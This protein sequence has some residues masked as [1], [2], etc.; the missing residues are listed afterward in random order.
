MTPPSAAA[1]SRPGD[2]AAA[3]GPLG[4]RAPRGPRRPVSARRGRT[5]AIIG[6]LTP[7]LLVYGAFMLYPL[8]RVVM[9][10][11]YEWDG[12]GVGR[13]VGV[14]NYVTTFSDDRLAGAFGHAL[15]LIVFYALLPLV[16]GLPLAT[17]LTRTRVRGIGLFRTLVFLPQVIAMVVLAVAWRRIYAPDGLLNTVLRA[18]GLDTLT[19]AWLGDFST[20]L[21]AVGLIGT[22][23][24]TGLVTVLLMS[25]IA[26]IPK[27]YYEAATLDG[28]GWW[29]RFRHITLDQLRPEIAV[30]LITT[31]VAALKVFAPIYILTKGGPGNA[32]IV[33]SYFSYY[34]FFTTMKVGY[35]SAVATVLA[36]LVTIIAVALLRYQTRTT[37]GF[38]E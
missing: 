6:L 37:E 35:G 23:V 8:A 10:S 15:V 19:R 22:W 33:P 12:L 31:S 30:V 38:E 21:V 26:G 18:V 14:D 16:I 29:Q 11:F 17:L 5:L 27:D 28:A 25:G 36:V 13:W 2:D 24:S 34:N 20:A 4:T 32:T 3:R 1:S 7:P 9:L